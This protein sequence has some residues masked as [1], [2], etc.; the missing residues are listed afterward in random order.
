MSEQGGRVILWPLVLA[1]VASVGYWYWSEIQGQGDLRAYGVA[2]FLPMLLI[3]VL[4]PQGLFGRVV[5]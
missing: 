3:L 1:G 5:A 4:R 2:Q